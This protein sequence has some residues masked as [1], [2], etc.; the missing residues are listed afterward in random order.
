[1]KREYIT[2]T[3]DVEEIMFVGVEVEHTP[4]HGMT[5]LFVAGKHDIQSIIDLANINNCTHIYLG[6]NQSFTYKDEADITEWEYL[7][8]GLLKEEFHVTLD[9]DIKFYQHI[10][11]TLSLFKDENDF[12]LML[13]VKIPYMEECLNYN[14]C[15]KLDD[16][17]F[18]ATNPGVWVHRIHE[19]KS[20]DKFTNWEQ[21]K[22]DKPI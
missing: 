19:L 12:I 15:L 14:A 16:T 2:G 1:M 17:D 7:V 5:T 22:S 13:S 6:A 8:I 18:N 11:D 4:A 20:L 21:Y 10:L 9:V 3:S